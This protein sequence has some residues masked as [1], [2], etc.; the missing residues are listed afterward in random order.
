MAG[1]KN[2]SNKTIYKKWEKKSWPI[3]NLIAEAKDVADLSLYIPGILFL[4]AKSG[5]ISNGY[6]Q[7]N[8]SEIEAYA[9]ETVYVKTKETKRLPEEIRVDTGAKAYLVLYVPGETRVNSRTG[10]DQVMTDCRYPLIFLREFPKKKC[11][12]VL[13]RNEMLEINALEGVFDMK[14]KLIS[15][16]TVRR[17]LPA[18]KKDLDA[19]S[20]ERIRKLLAQAMEQN[21]CILASTFPQVTERIF[22]AQC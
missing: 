22:S 14:A 7:E 3:R 19:K 17:P 15:Q 9:G 6:F 20:V 5:Y 11:H 10:R 13:I 12:Y 2:E 18:E 1:L 21:E 16:K 4:W 8:Y